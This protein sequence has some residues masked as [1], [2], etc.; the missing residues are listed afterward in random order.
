MTHILIIEDDQG[1]SKNLQILLSVEGYEVR[2][3]NDGSEGLRMAQEHSPDLVISDIMMPKLDGYGVLKAMRQD[4]GLTTIPF[5]F[6]SAKAGRTDL[7]Q[8]MNLGADD[9]LTKPFTRQEL[10]DSVSSRLQRR[11]AIESHYRRRSQA[12]V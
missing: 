10:L 7:R 5:I 6:L 2:V 3:A 11:K 12:A 4:P 1:I 9:Y 8:G